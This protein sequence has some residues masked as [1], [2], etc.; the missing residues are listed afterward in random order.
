MVE[1]LRSVILEEVLVWQ[2]LGFGDVGVAVARPYSAS[3][4]R[5]FRWCLGWNVVMSSSLKDW[6]HR[7]RARRF[8]TAALPSARMSWA[9][10][11][12]HPRASTI[13]NELLLCRCVLGLGLCALLEEEE[14]RLCMFSGCGRGGSGLPDHGREEPLLLI[15][16]SLED[17]QGVK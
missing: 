12:E 7:P 9:S 2:L 3:L 11:V 4:C 16:C 17:D 15:S 5:Y 8:R 6:L 10:G 14:C 1:V 13:G